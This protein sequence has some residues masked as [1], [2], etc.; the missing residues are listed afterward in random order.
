MIVLVHVFMFCFAFTGSVFCNRMYR[1]V[2]GEGVSPYEAALLTDLPRMFF[3]PFGKNIL[4]LSSLICG[5]SPFL[6]LILFFFL[7]EVAWYWLI[8]GWISGFISC[9]I[10]EQLIHPSIVILCSPL[11]LVIINVFLV[12]KIFSD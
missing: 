2:T 11:A 4:I 9:V 12:M 8:V 1:I 6:H 3:A 7:P 5:L 10:S